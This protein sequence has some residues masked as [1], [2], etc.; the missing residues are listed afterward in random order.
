MANEAAIEMAE[1]S[2]A[3]LGMLVEIARAHGGSYDDREES[4]LLV[5][6]NERYDYFD[7]IG[8]EFAT[9]ALAADFARA[10]AALGWTVSPYTS[11]YT[12]DET[13]ERVITR[14]ADVRKGK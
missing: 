10:G 7:F 9:E 4:G 14:R 1:I 11:R 5:Y 12:D 13:G 8:V 2:D 6:V 3:R